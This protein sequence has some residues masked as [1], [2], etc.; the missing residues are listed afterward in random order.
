MRSAGPRTL[1]TIGYQGLTPT[2]FVDRL[3]AHR[4][5]MIV[6]VRESPFSRKPGFSKSTLQN[7]LADEGIEY[8]HL[9]RLGSPREIRN[10]LREKG[11]FAAFSES[12][13]SYLASASSDLDRLESLAVVKPTAIMCFEQA[14]EQCHR[15]IIAAALGQRGFTIKD[16]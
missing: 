12:Y 15:G 9:R 10:E 16:L 1:F 8:L 13:R 2:E 7:L 3:K 5:S 4:V 6:D 11:D 14:V